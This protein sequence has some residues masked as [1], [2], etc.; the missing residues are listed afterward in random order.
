MRKITLRNTFLLILS[1]VSFAAQAQFQGPGF[2]RIRVLG[3][4]EADN[5]YATPRDPGQTGQQP[6]ELQPIDTQ[7]NDQIFEFVL[8]GETFEDSEGVTQD[9]YNF[10]SVAGSGNIE[11][12]NSNVDGVRS[13]TNPSGRAN[14]RGASTAGNEAGDF[15]NFFIREAVDPDTGEVSF[16]RIFGANAD[17]R[18][19][20]GANSS[21]GTRFL[22][23]GTGSSVFNDR[24]SIEP[25]QVL[26]TQT[27]D[28]KDFFVSNPIQ[29]VLEI[30]GLSSSID[31]ITVYDIIGKEVLSRDIKSNFA[32]LNVSSLKSGLYIVKLS[33]SIGT[34]STKITKL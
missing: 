9:V 8:T 30:K 3:E 7:T 14:L 4:F 20:Q 25:A 10:R 21:G 28:S 19:L 15:D 13:I 27:L 11:A 1:I 24:M 2:Y 6:I 34:F 17:G 23:F 31:N 33:S 16:Y 22:N 32:S 29:N 26:S 18:R 12:A 5:I